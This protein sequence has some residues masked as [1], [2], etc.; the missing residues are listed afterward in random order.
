MRILK[1][2]DTKLRFEELMLLIDPEKTHLHGLEAV[3]SLCKMTNEEL[4]MPNDA[5]Q[6]LALAE[7]KA[8]NLKAIGIFEMFNVQVEDELKIDNEDLYKVVC[9]NFVRRARDGK[10]VKES[11]KNLDSTILSTA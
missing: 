1:I 11:S 7:Q 5:G 8:N 3:K 10:L 9:L 6:K 2:T 4:R